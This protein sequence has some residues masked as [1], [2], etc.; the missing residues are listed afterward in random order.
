MKR[1]YKQFIKQQLKHIEVLIKKRAFEDE[2]M[3]E[4]SVL[5]YLL[6]V[7]PEGTKELQGRK[8]RRNLAATLD[9]II[10]TKCFS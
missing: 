8:M 1:F 4:N 6:N 10:M 5:Q 7:D 3:T 2:L 9:H